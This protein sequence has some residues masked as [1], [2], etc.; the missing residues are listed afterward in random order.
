[1]K[2]ELGYAD[3]NIPRVPEK[4]LKKRI[5]RALELGYRTVAVNTTIHQVAEF[6]FCF[7]KVHLV[8]LKLI[9]EVQIFLLKFYT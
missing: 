5:Q 7:T 8:Y 6:H 3:L 1:M 2:D 4:T 9:I